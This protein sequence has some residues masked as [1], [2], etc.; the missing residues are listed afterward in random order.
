MTQEQSFFE[1]TT[2]E[3]GGRMPSFAAVGLAPCRLL[4]VVTTASSSSVVELEDGEERTVGRA[5][6]ADIVLP[7][8]GL[9]RV[10]ARLRR[11]GAAVQLTDLGSRNGS[12]LEGRRV[13]QALA[14][15][16]DTFVLSHATVTV[17]LTPMPLARTLGLASAP[18]APPCA[19]PESSVRV[20]ESTLELQ[21]QVE[22]LASRSISVLL[23][24]ETGT[25]KELIA[26][27]LHE[28]GER[29]QRP[30]KVVNCGAIPSQLIE[31]VLFGHVRGSF[32]GAHKDQP[33]LFVQ[34]HGGTLFLDEVGELS[35]AAQAALLRVLDTRRV[36]AV[37]S[38]QEQTVDVRVVAATH[39]DLE[40]MTRKGTFRL[41]LY[42]RLNSVVLRVPPLRERPE[43]I[44][45]LFEHFLRV[46]SPEGSALPHVTAEARARL[47]AYAWPG[48]VRELRN[49]A[50]RALALL[51]AGRISEADLPAHLGKDTSVSALTPAVT[52][53]PR[54]QSATLPGMPLLAAVKS[55]GLR[56]LMR[57]QEASI[58][59]AALEQS[60]GN[61]RR[62][63]ERLHVP[64]RTLER[65]LRQLR[66][67]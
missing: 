18:S 23:Q 19:A 43:E 58:I 1:E 48:N 61:Q 50:E 2:I 39:R 17:Q 16:G 51:E 66:K 63:A 41:D 62:A 32:T 21:R 20:S 44:L 35:S 22:R 64:L 37:G 6:P 60:G 36:C 5:A 27:E 54:A 49:V 42:H 12:W 38:N 55:A 3:R 24:G 46:G 57:E 33:G 65:K 11:D 28:R 47:Q 7:D 56:T 34:A 26:R 52:P 30:L 25:G 4:L 31:S 40:A 13:E 67:R 10:H 59:E 14:H 9:S 45:P 15:V 53:A 8:P 29:A